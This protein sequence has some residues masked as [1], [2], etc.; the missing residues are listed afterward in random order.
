LNIQSKATPA[1]LNNVSNLLGTTSTEDILSTI[2]PPA[3]PPAAATTIQRSSHRTSQSAKKW[4]YLSPGCMAQSQPNADNPLSTP[5]DSLTDHLT[6]QT[7]CNDPNRIQRLVQAIEAI[8]SAAR[9]PSRS[10]ETLWSAREGL[11]DGTETGHEGWMCRLVRGRKRIKESRE[12][13][14]CA[15]RL[16]LMFAVQF[17]DYMEKWMGLP[18]KSGQSGITRRTSACKAVSQDWGIEL[19][20][21]IKYNQRSGTYFYLLDKAGPGILL[22]L[23]SKVTYL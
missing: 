12:T 23:G 7:G 14:D 21:V 8:K 18:L 5:S 16:S 10:Y 20:K 17:V 13:L 22:E 11:F 3:S 4:H 19:K 6:I 1:S 9:L 15:S 2:S